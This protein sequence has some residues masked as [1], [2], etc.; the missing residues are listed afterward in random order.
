MDGQINAKVDE[1]LDIWIENEW[2]GGC[3]PEVLWR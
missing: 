1:R 3:W 2:M